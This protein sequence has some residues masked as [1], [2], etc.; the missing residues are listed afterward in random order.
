M[1]GRSI[2]MLTLSVGV[3]ALGA[4]SSVEDLL[5]VD[6]GHVQFSCAASGPLAMTPP[7]QSSLDS[8]VPGVVVE[9]RRP[10]PQGMTLITM[11]AASAADAFSFSWQEGVAGTARPPG[12]WACVAAW[13]FDGRAWRLSH[14]NVHWLGVAAE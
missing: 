8:L 1:N 13:R 11:P 6:S 9:V 7:L 5:G 3:L 4:C 12:V 14:F 2:Q 10:P